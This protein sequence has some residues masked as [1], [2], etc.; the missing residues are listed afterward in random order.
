MM[1][2][3]ACN[4]EESEP[5]PTT[6]Q[7]TS[8]ELSGDVTAV[9]IENVDLDVS[10]PPPGERVG[11][12]V[13]AAI[14]VNL[15]VN[16]E[17]L[18]DASSQLCGL[19]VGQDVVVVVT[20]ETDLEFDRPLNELGTLEDESIRAT[21]TARETAAVQSPG[22]GT[23]GPGGSCEFAARTLAVVEEASP[24]PT[25]SPTPSPLN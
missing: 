15:T 10:V 25:V 20:E 18:D 22:Q 1:L 24:A 3:P 4:T 9:D 11:I 7:E 17:T 16:I 8:F 2:L 5:P 23:T 6:G 19:E 12:D 14:T 21:G 13:D